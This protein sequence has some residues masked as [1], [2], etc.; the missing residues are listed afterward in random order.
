MAR[1]A[2]ALMTDRRIAVVVT[3]HDLGRT[4]VEA[5][6]SVTRQTRPASEV[7]VADDGSSDVYTQQVLAGLE[8]T[9][10]RVI[11]TGGRGA[12]AARNAGARLTSAEY[13]VWLDADD[14]LEPGY[15]TAAAT[16]LDNEDAIDFVSCAM[17][18]FGAADYVWS[19]S[20][21]T[22][23]EAISTGAVPHAS[24]MIRRRVWEAAGEF[25]ESL[26]S[27]ELLDFWAT[28]FDRGGR[29]VVL[30]EPLLK[31]RVRAGSGYRR[32]IQPDTYRERLRHFYE[33]HRASVER[34]W[35]ELIAGKEV[36]LLS[37]IDYRRTL[38]TRAGALKVE[39]ADLQR[40]IAESA[41]ALEARGQSR[42][43]WGDL[44]RVQPLSPCWGL[45]RGQPI[46][47]YY[48][49]RFLE[50][51]RA[52]I[53]GRVLE[54]RDARY[55]R[56]F[57]RSAVTSS[58]VV[59]VDA[60]NENAT[61]VADLRN[62]A[63]IP[64]GSY[65][66]I[67]LTQVLQFIDD[68]HA[69]LA[70]CLRILRPGGTLLVTA[71]CV[72]RVDTEAGPDGDYWRLTEASARKHFAALFPAESFEVSTFGNVGACTA[73][74][75]GISVEEVQPADLDPV[76]PA[77]PLLVAI[78]AVKPAPIA[79]PTAGPLIRPAA[80]S[81]RGVVLV[82]HRVATLQPD[83]HNLCTPP[84][85]FAEH[86][87][88]LARDFTPIGLDDL[89][90][91]ASAGRIP[92]RAVAVTLDDG[93]LDALTTA[94]PILTA[95]GVPAT[96]FINSDRL[97][98]EHE[99]WWDLL[100]RLPLPAPE[101]E[102]LNRSMWPLDANGRRQF[103]ADVL[104]RNGSDMLPRASHRVMTAKEVREL[105]SRPGHHIGAHTV[106]HLALTTQPLETRQCE[107]IA[108]KAALEQALGRPVTLFSYPYGDYD[109]DVVSVVRE[110]GFRAAVTVEAGLVSTDTDRLLLPRYEVTVRDW[111]D[112][113]SRLREAFAQM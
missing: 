113:P 31:Y 58:D 84:E 30:E 39:L 67:I 42:V 82:Y 15:F 10:T 9:G 50:R 51:H 64:A 93:Y 29:G 28:V 73:F 86:M 43:D 105:A 91:A 18:A 71:P 89:V 106:H 101:L 2:D 3:C 40:E 19:P 59:D 41:R 7:V 46:D 6:D 14:V 20:A 74:L 78:R 92:E 83:S 75:H 77:F 5:L 68:I 21:T 103:I 76:D 85:V 52:G 53:R 61:I 108:D 109:A 81:H 16:R 80:T 35:P 110:A 112:F 36:F 12:S 111:Q 99:R 104:A 47:R 1:L 88:C 49:D 55:T 26:R 54:V 100:E 48:I 34:H 70:E 63:T 11:Q 65:D 13:L 4:L 87:S 102:A 23:V 90:E 96:F 94:S 27:F 8:R 72:I 97:G 62:A 38:E 25:D 24:T 66:C 45:D 33:K 60:A 56:Q 79:H 98:H 69:A 44:R 107:V 37:Q 32:S 57:G 17:R 95:L 22:F